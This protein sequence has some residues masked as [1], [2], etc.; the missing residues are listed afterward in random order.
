MDGRSTNTGHQVNVQTRVQLIQQQMP[1]TYKAIQ[2]KAGEIGND[3]YALVRRGLRGEANCFYAMEA[4]H[5]V[6]TPFSMSDVNAELAQYIVRFGCSFLIMWA[7]R[8]GE[9]GAH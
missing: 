3:A 6:G 5:V 8:E 2:D 9:H 7:P 4:G 1:Q